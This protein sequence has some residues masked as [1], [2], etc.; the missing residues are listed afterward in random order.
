LIGANLTTAEIITIGTELLLGE[1]QDT[2]KTYLARQLRQ[3]GVDLFRTTTV[4]DNPLRI[5]DA[6]QES[7]TRADIVITT[8][9]LGPTIDD[10]TRNAVA[11]AFKAEMEFHADLWDSIINRFLVRGITPTENNRKQAYLPACAIGI[12][13]PVG[14]APAFYILD[15]NKM[16]VCLPGVPAE[17]ET[18]FERSV[19]RLIQETFSIQQVLLTRVVHVVGL[20]ESLIDERIA[21]LE[22][23]TNPTVGLAAHPGVVDVRITAK[24]STREE[25]LLLIHQVESELERRLP[26]DIVGVD[27]NTL[28]QQLIT[29]IKSTGHKINVYLYGASSPRFLRHDPDLGKWL[30]CTHGDHPFS[31]QSGIDNP[32]MQDYFSLNISQSKDAA[33]I[34]MFHVHQQQMMQKTRFYNGPP[35]QMEQWLENISLD[36]IWRQLKNTSSWSNE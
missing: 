17:M 10:P 15:D 19:I 31:V 36:F 5:A 32:N 24:A 27:E 16:I 2:N 25:A 30:S 1:I 14:T 18:I 29:L 13:N 33:S 8:G 23:L 12:E 35:S 21:D 22:T 11:I 20:G 26:E 9:G 7:F 3:L 28:Q 4:G 6:I 34:E